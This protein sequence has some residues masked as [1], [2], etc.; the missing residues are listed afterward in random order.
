[1]TKQ[2]QSLKPGEIKLDFI[3][4]EW[5]L[6]PLGANKDPYIICWQNKPCS[7]HEI[8]AEILTGQ[9]KAI[10]LLSGPVFN[11]PYGLVWVDVD[12]PSVYNLIEGL[13]DG[14]IDKV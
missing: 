11:L 7:V 13:A 1:M 8:E 6:T 3:S 10:G 5:P 14:E 12:G 9:C 4:K 2:T